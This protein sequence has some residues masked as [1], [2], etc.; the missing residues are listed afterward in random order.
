ME[1]ENSRLYYEDSY[2]FETETIISDIDSTNGFLLKFEK[3]IFHPQGGGQPADEGLILFENKEFQILQIITDKNS[4]EIWHEINP[5]TTQFRI[6]DKILMKINPE[7]RVHY[8]RL[9]SAG[10]LID[11]CISNLNIGL[12]AVKGY[13]FPE[14]PYVEYTGQIPSNLDNLKENVEKYCEE[15]INGTDEKWNVKSGIYTYE[16]AIQLFKV[17]SYVL[18]DKSTRFLRLIEDD[19]GRPCGGT[20]VKHVKEIGKLLISK[21]AKKG[22]NLRVSYLVK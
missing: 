8:A 14:G 16:E 7:K 20:H 5:Q 18:K 10:H 11:I 3:T 2:L 4:D 21:I 15:K 22:K 12:N 1:S 6:N 17:P 13:H 19:Y 9:H